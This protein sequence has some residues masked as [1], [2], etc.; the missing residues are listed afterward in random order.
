MM[1][2]RIVATEAAKHA[3]SVIPIVFAVAGDPVGSG[4]VASL[5]RPGGNVTGLSLQQSDIA[6]KRLELLRELVPG[7]DRLGVMANISNPGSAL[8]MRRHRRDTAARRYRGRF[9]RAQEPSAGG[10]C[11][12]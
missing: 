11:R 1:K 5:A 4:L 10:L 3:T 8:E 9:R 12:Q 6:A 2:R 7:L